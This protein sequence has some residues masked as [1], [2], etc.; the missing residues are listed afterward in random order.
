M[1]VIFIDASS[2]RIGKWGEPYASISAAAAAH[3]GLTPRGVVSAIFPAVQRRVHGIHEKSTAVRVECDLPVRAVHCLER[4]TARDGGRVEFY[5]G[6]TSCRA[7]R[8]AGIGFVERTASLG[9]RFLGQR[10]HTLHRQR[11]HP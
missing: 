1:S 2:A 7:P 11:V 10:A 8:L 4:G 9:A 3:G 6:T 5:R